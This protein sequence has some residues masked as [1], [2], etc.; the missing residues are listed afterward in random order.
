[1]IDSHRVLKLYAALV[2]LC[3][4][5]PVS[6]L[7]G[8]LILLLSLQVFLSW[9]LS[10]A[11]LHWQNLNRLLTCTSDFHCFG[12]LGIWPWA[13][14]MVRVYCEVFGQNSYLFQMSK[15]SQFFLGHN[16]QSCCGQTHVPL[17][18][19]ETWK[20]GIMPASNNLNCQ[21]KLS[22]KHKAYAIQKQFQASGTF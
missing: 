11:I 20:A 3:G 14:T 5:E 16:F 7:T 21:L 8:A 4:T 18:P 15:S 2:I 12:A 13:W 6:A 22:K 9:S 10:V 19:A 17:W 1:M